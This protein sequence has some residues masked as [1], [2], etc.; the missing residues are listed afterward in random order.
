MTTLLHRRRSGLRSLATLIAFALGVALATPAVAAGG[1]AGTGAKASAAS[2]DYD[3][4]LTGSTATT[5][6]VPTPQAPASGNL[7]ALVGGGV[8]VDEAFRRMIAHTGA[9][10][11]APMRFVVVRAT[12]ADGYNPYIPTLATGVGSVETLVVK[13]SAGANLAF[14]VDKVRAAHAVFIAGGDQA[15]Y[16]RLW[17]G[18]ALEQALKD[19]MR[20]NKPVGG[21]SAGL[22]VLGGVDNTALTGSVTSA[23]ALANPYSRYVTLGS[24]F[25]ETTPALTTTILDSHFVTRDRMGRLVTFLARMTKDVG[26]SSIATARAIG[27]NEQ[28]ALMVSNGSASVVGN[29][30]LPGSTATQ[31]KAYFLKPAGNV[32]GQLLSGKPLDWNSG[33]TMHTLSS[34][35][36]TFD[37]V[38]WLPSTGSAQILSVSGGTLFPASPY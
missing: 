24:D 34:A 18:S 17:N 31:C 13:T 11:A 5:L 27:V 14:V 25:L 9:S 32:P 37:L 22:A 4:Y 6:P 23:Q 12:G 33:V 19:S 7:L 35:G 10:T 21:T 15:D 28:T 29:C 1:G 20:A 30:G 26:P 38:N 16:I 8:D 36:G 3:Y 2:K